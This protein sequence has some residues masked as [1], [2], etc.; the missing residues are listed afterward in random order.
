MIDFALSLKTL[1]LEFSSNFSPASAESDF[2]E[3]AHNHPSEAALEMKDCKIRRASGMSRDKSSI[4]SMI[5][6]NPF[7]T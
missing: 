1:A 6:L 4:E 2:R 5:L 7:V 3:E